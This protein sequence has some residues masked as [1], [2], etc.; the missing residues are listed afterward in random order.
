MKYAKL[1][2]Q[3]IGV[4]PFPESASGKSEEGGEVE[5]YKHP[6]V[7]LATIWPVV[8]I[9]DIS[10]PKIARHNGEWNFYGAAFFELNVL[11][12]P[13]TPGVHLPS[14]PSFVCTF[15]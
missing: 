1:H 3:S 12:R 2:I 6:Y 13:C 5:Y 7:N 9:T 10:Q 8:A 4:K 14:L 11:S 15:V